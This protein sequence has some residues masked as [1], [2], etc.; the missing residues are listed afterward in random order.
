LICVDANLHKLQMTET[1]IYP[2]SQFILLLINHFIYKE[3][4]VI[5]YKAVNIVIKIGSFTCL[6]KYV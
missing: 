1:N 4:I 2:Y 6:L 5:I 3:N